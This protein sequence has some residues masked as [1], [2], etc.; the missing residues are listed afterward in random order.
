MIAYSPLGRGFLNG[1]FRQDEDFKE[2]DYRK[3]HPHFQGENFKII[4]N[5]ST[6]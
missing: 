6:R 1:R 5:S 3:T 2:G 4:R